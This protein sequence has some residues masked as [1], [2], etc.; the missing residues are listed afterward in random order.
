MRLLDPDEFAAWAAG[1]AIS[2]P[3]PGSVRL[4]YQPN[5][6]HNRF[7]PLPG[8][9]GGY[10]DLAALMLDG[11]EPW[12][13]CVAWFPY[14]KWNPGWP[15]SKPEWP[16]DRAD[17][18]RTAILR[19]FGIPDRFEGAVEF[20]RT[21]RG[22]LLAVAFLQMIY[23][24]NVHDDVHLIPDH[25][26]AFLMVSH[27]DVIHATFARP[28]LIPPFV[29]H[30]TRHGCPLPTEPPDPTFKRRRWMKRSTEDRP[31]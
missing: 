16:D 22:Q 21:E 25:G 7:W 5:R 10:P 13:S 19:G 29:A 14:S 24:G 4:R 20:D 2:L 11:L 26:R 15:V 1:R 31:G 17:E 18:L 6:R 30:L 3:D 9:V 28:G 23:G 12:G 8:A 27:H